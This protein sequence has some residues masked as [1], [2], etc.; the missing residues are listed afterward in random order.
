M[1]PDFL[2]QVGGELEIN[3]DIL[4]HPPEKTTNNSDQERT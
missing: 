2:M 3:L 1:I 4:R